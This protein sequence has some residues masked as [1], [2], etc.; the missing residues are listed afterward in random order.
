MPD[1]EHTKIKVIRQKHGYVWSCA[2]CNQQMALW[3]NIVWQK[4]V[5]DRVIPDVEL[6][7]GEGFTFNV[8]ERGI[9]AEPSQ[10]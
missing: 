3:N 6:G 5:A 9:D 4:I 2:D 10:V 1:C 8:V 7:I